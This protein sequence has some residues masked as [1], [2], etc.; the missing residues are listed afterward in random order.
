[1]VISGTGI[2]TFTAKIKPDFKPKSY[3]ALQWAQAADMNWHATD[4]GSARDY[5]ECEDFRLYA[6]ENVINNF[7]NQVENSRVSG[8]NTL[9]LSSFSSTE[10]IFGEGIVYSGNLTVT[11]L[12]IPS[13]AQNTWKGWSITCKLRLLS[14]YAYTS[15]TATLPPLRCVDVGY[16]ADSE[17]TITKIDTYNNAFT[18][19]DRVCDSG[20]F[21]G[22][23]LFTIPQMEQLKLFAVLIRATPFSISKIWGVNYPWGRRTTTYPIYANLKTIE[24]EQMEGVHRWKCKLTFVEFKYA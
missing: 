7:I 13:R 5:Y 9:T 21:T 16:S 8:D 10:H 18:Y 22:T 20:V 2:T 14:P 6:K 11:V 4:R 23:F 19:V 24:D 15:S 1:M 3:Y 12:E 17:R